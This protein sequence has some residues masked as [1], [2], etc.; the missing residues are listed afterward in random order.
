[1]SGAEARGVSGVEARAQSK[2]IKPTQHMK[3]KLLLFSTLF[4]SFWLQAQEDYHGNCCPEPPAYV[5][6]KT[7]QEIYKDIEKLSFLGSVLY[8]AA[9]P[10]DENTRLIAYLS[11]EVKAITAYLSLTR[12]DG[13]QNRI[14]SELRELLGVIRTQ[15]LLAARAIDGGKQYFS[16]ANDFGYSK[17]PEETLRFWDR[18][19]VLADMVWVIRR[20]RPDII[21][22][23]FDHRTPGSTHGHHTASAMLSLEAF[24]LA[25]DNSAFAEQLQYT[26]P[27]Q[28]DRLLL[29]ISP[30][31][32]KDQAAFES[33]D[34]SEFITLDVNAYY[35]AK[36]KSNA[37]M[38]AEARSQHRCQAMG[39]S[40]KRGKQM[41]YL[42]HI[43]GNKPKD[44]N[45]IFSGI[46]TT[47]SRVKDGAPIAD[48]I[49]K[50]LADY[51]FEAPYKSLPALVQLYHEMDALQDCHWKRVKMEALKKIL[52]QVANIHLVALSKE[53]T[54][55]A[56]EVLDLTLEV[57]RR[58][59]GGKFSAKL[60]GYTIFEN[61]HK[62]ET[63][64]PYGNFQRI[65]NKITIPK[66]LGYDNPYWL[67]GEATLGMYEVSD[68][69]LRGKPEAMPKLSVDVRLDFDG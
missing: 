16:R 62:C 6:G 58:S 55:V 59:S 41:E 28:A 17:V 42:E 53:D 36:G 47:W 23:R 67:Q 51:H 9:H 35:P 43:A 69:L 21:I 45:N 63:D 8:L 10:D 12:G 31:F 18:E 22:N 4:M 50:I 40:P 33:A 56:G 37:E 48:M 20:F 26:A 5:A 44:K 49:E 30:W 1:M 24:S 25:S 38:A 66:T 46:N 15:E 34:K 11:N 14:G 60:I 27:H 2:V 3:K 61:F 39:T 54:Y 13:G 64:F 7:A 65:E 32:Y 57:L 68:I 52:L 19:K 29:N